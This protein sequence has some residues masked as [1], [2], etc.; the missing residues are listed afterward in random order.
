M[1]SSP[2]PH[3]SR[4]RAPRTPS[5]VQ[6]PTRFFLCQCACARALAQHNLQVGICALA[7][8]LQ[9]AGGRALTLA[10]FRVKYRSVHMLACTRDWACVPSLLYC[11]TANSKRARVHSPVADQTASRAQ[12]RR[13]RW[14]GAC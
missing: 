11:D 14:A 4:S 7:A 12:N 13:R 6:R 9:T 5:Q 2:A 10:L 8:V 1:T 3:A